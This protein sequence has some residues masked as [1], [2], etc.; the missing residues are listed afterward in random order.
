MW[1]V[2]LYF[3]SDPVEFATF[4][5]LPALRIVEVQHEKHH[6]FSSCIRNPNCAIHLHNVRLIWAP[7][8][9]AVRYLQ[10]GTGEGLNRR[11]SSW[12]RN[13]TKI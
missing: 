9:S 1:S 5:F 8:P 4:N 6:H 13:S 12:I 10:L 2:D 11:F 3:Y 7:C